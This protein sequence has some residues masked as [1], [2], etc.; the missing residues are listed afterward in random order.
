MPEWRPGV[1]GG[2]LKEIEAAGRAN[3][4]KGLLLIANAIEAKAKA[5]LGKTSHSFGTPSPASKGQA[6]ALVTGTGRR[7]M[8]HQYM[9]STA[10]ITVR[11]GTLAGVFP[12]ANL[13]RTNKG[14]R[15]RAASGTTSSRGKTPSSKYLWYQ[16][17]VPHFD[18]PFLVP[19]FKAVVHEDS[20]R[21]W[22]ESFRRFPRLV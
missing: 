11:V 14:G 1:L 18:H 9:P 10:E 8:G 12:P 4:R 3:Q 5:E 21:I 6:P 22:L 13:S 20:V 7:S 19:S 2:L 17:T 15:S 16:E